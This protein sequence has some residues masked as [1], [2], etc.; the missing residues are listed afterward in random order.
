VR[1]HADGS[2]VNTA[3]A[4]PE[5]WSIGHRNMQGTAINPISKVLWTSEHGPQGDDE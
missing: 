4:L 2:F 5:I 1:I 3:G